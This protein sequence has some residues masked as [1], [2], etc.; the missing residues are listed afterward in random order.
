MAVPTASPAPSADPHTSAGVRSVLDRMAVGT[1]RR[2]PRDDSA[3][4]AER[5]YSWIN[6]TRGNTCGRARARS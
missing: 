1:L 6:S 5:V 4:I 3:S 2:R